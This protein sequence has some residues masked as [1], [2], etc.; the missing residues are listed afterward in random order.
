M[1]RLKELICELKRKKQ[2]RRKENIRVRANEIYQIT[3]FSGKLWF[4]C[5]GFL[6][7]PCDLVKEDPVDALN[8]LRSC[9][10]SRNCLV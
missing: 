10:V 2:E 1:E 6:F 3:E 4:T 7:C 9:Y 8:E 5:N